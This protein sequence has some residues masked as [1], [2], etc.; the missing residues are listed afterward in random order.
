MDA[1]ISRRTLSD[2]IHGEQSMSYYRLNLECLER[3]QRI[4]FKHFLV[5]CTELDY[6]SF[7]NVVFNIS[8]GQG[9]KNV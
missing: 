3:K 5:K 1:V 8:T 6:D 7:L 4:T 2:F 9:M